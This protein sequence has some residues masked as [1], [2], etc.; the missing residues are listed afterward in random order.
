V[1]IPWLQ[2]KSKMKKSSLFFYIFSTQKTT[3]PL[4][5]VFLAFFSSQS[6]N[7]CIKIFII[8]CVCVLS[9]YSKKNELISDV[10][11]FKEK[12]ELIKSI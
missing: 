5:L 10:E 9:F 4:S 8:I 7:I 1:K 6:L 2:L 12:K 3:Q 11:L